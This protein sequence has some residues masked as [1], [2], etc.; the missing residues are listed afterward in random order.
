MQ[1]THSILFQ[2]SPYGNLNAIVEHDD[3]SVYFYLSGGPETDNRF[4]TR[5]CWVR[6]LALGPHVINQQDMEL[7]IAPML[8]RYDCVDPHLTRLP[9][10]ETLEIVWFEEGNGA[11][12]FELPGG[13]SDL[14]EPLLLA[15][16]PPWSGLDGFHGYASNCVNETSV[17]WPMPD[18]PML[19]QRIKRSQEFWNQWAQS[20]TDPAKGPF[21]VQQPQ[22]LANYRERFEIVAGE[23]NYFSVGEGVFP[24]RGLLR[25]QTERFEVVATVGM[26]V[27]PQP[28]VEMFA[29]DPSKFRRI[30]LAL[31]LPKEESSQSVTGALAQV[32]RL[33][34]Y[35]WQQLTWLGPGHTCGFS[36]NDYSGVLLIDDRL[37]S[38]IAGVDALPLP[39]WRGDPVNLLWMLPV[40]DKQMEQLNDQTLLVDDLIAKWRPIRS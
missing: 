28:A 19:T 33:S 22:I 39:A 40:T 9:T 12:L 32:S 7:G 31:L 2:C 4:G 11:A 17:C 35:P 16:I 30:E 25:H 37:G 27:Y 21:A 14:T 38:G 34:G 3:R 8:P 1:P 6:N 20:R 5:A 18:N 23:E 10:A 15:V 13:Q 24:V 29:D 26:S 36:F